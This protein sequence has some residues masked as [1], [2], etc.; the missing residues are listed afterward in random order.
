[1]AER[2]ERELLL[3]I[4]LME[5]WDTAGSLE[6]GLAELTAAEPPSKEDMASLVVLAHRLKG[7]AALYGFTGVAELAAAGE[8]LLERAPE[9]S[10][11]ERAR[12]A[13]FLVGL[14]TVLKEVFDGISAVGVEDAARIGEFKAR[15]PMFLSAVNGTTPAVPAA[16]ESVAPAAPRSPVA[17]ALDRFFR[18][19]REV[20]EYFLPEASEHLE[21]MITALLAVEAGARDEETLATV[22]RSVHTLKGAAYTVGCAPIGDA[23]HQIEDLLGAVRENRLT[24]SPAV[25]EALFVGTT[26]IKQVLQ[27]GGTISDDT[28]LALAGAT[29][30]LR[31]I[32]T[33][34]LAPPPV[35]VAEPTDDAAPV[36]AIR[37]LPVTA[38]EPVIVASAVPTPIAPPA[39]PL[40]PTWPG[41]AR[42]EFL[43]RLEALP[44]PAPRP[45]SSPSG[46]SIRVPVGAARRAHEPGRR[47]H[48]RRSRL[49]A[50]PRPAR[51]GQPSSLAFSRLAQVGRDFEFLDTRPAPHA[52]L[53]AALSGERTESTAIRTSS[54]SSSSTATTTSISSPGAWTRS[55]PT[56]GGPGQHARLLRSIGEDTAHLQRL[57][58]AAS[59]GNHPGAHGAHRAALHTVGSSRSARPRGPPGRASRSSCAARPSR[60]TTRHR[61]D[62]GSASSPDPERDGH[63]IEAAEERQRRGQARGGPPSSSSRLPGGRSF[64]SRWRTT[65]AASTPPACGA[66]GASG[67][68]CRPPTPRRSTREASI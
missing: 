27:S 49:D 52:Q 7:S 33:S 37:T 57:T 65:A 34:A 1:M 63:G 64:S 36:E 62:R 20:L 32:M 59:Q 12:G 24:L 16:S 51:S 45:A 10:R 44:R 13:G 58:A 22:F 39:P 15:Y 35:P 5:A 46:P 48:D 54:P 38:S 56:W 23:A 66:R 47:A 17:A 21:A 42:P 68:F 30:D 40:A 41:V 29:Q 67:A 43:A 9:A 11:E 4:F 2:R 25:T 14:V 19:G 8:R 60:W 31:A 28:A 55:R 18:D 61:A 53:P 3:G 26:A 6:E 50:S